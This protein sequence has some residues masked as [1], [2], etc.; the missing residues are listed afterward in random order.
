MVR[1]PTYKRD[2]LVNVAKKLIYSQGFNI[3]TLVDIA[4]EAGV[5]LGNLY[6]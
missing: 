2:A 3:T 5:P 6:Y 4:N 1:K